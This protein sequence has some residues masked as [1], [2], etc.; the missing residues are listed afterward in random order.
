VVIK[1]EKTETELIKSE[2]RQKNGKIDALN[3]ELMT[4][5]VKDEENEQ[6]IMHSVNLNLPNAEIKETWE[7]LQSYLSDPNCKHDSLVCLFEAKI[8][9]FMFFNE[10][11]GMDK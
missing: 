8:M 9:K 4:L 3:E 2:C 6:V 11:I 10:S 7:A 5:M 1:L